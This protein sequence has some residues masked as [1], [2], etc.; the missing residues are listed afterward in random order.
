MWILASITW[1]LPTY[2]GKMVYW[3]LFSSKCDPKKKEFH[4]VSK[5]STY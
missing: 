5:D 4:R 1:H 2:D 3:R